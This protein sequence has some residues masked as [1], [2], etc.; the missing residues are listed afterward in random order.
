MVARRRYRRNPSG[1]RFTLRGFTTHTL[2]PST[3]GAIGALGVDM[4]LNL[5]PVPVAMKT[6]IMAPV[7]R[8]AGA[9]AIG[10]LV[11][12]VANRRMGEQAAAGAITVV[13]YDTIKGM[14]GA[15]VPGLHGLYGDYPTMEYVSPAATVDA[16]LGAYL[17]AGGEGVA[18]MPSEGAFGWGSELGEYIS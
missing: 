10:A 11:G 12:M 5:L 6:G 2:V 9:V 13:L 15:K 8:I 17:P 1:G 16:D 3:I 7:T 18:T 4:A 14:I